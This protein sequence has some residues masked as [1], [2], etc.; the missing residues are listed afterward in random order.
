MDIISEK[1]TFTGALGHSITAR[2]DQPK[3]DVR[4]YTIYAPC[5]TC[6]KDFHAATRIAT[7]LANHN[8]ATLRLD[9]TGLG[10]SAGQFSETSFVSNVNDLQ[11][12][13]DYLSQSYAPPQMIIGHSWGGTASLVA[14]SLNNNIKA[15]VTIN[16]PYQPSHVAHHFK[17]LPQYTEDNKMYSVH[18]AGSDYYVHSEFFIDLH[19]YKM[20]FVLSNLNAALLVLHTPQ[21]DT[22]DIHNANDIFLAARHPKSFI[23]LHHMD[24]LIRKREDAEYIAGLISQWS[25][26]YVIDTA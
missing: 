10:E 26:R 22:V 25:K 3:Q 2:L 14:A 12:A 6:T 23:S 1:V 19:K 5:F 21:D 4:F 24:H 11:R 13:I 8:I 9:F 15:V 16:S 7:A 20:D 18:I 17:D